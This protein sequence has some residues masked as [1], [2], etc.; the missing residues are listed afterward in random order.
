MENKRPVFV[1]GSLLPGF[2]NHRLFVEPYQHRSLAAQ[3]KGTLYHLPTGYP[4]LLKETDSGVTGWVKGEILLFADDA[5]AKAMTGLDELETY[6]APGD[7]RNEYERIV[8]EAVTESGEVISVCTY[9]YG[10]PAYAKREGI[11]IPDGDWRAFI[12]RLKD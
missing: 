5:Y 11:L 7:P 6:F 10:D 8:T 12:K 4:G 9:L 1:Y 3:V 2:H